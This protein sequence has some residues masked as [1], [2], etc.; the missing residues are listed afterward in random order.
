MFYF[1]SV[2][3]FVSVSVEFHLMFVQIISS[4]VWVAE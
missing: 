3:F 1:F 4:L 2:T